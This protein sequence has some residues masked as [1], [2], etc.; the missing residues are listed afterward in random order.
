LHLPLEPGGRCAL[1]ESELEQWLAAVNRL[2]PRAPISR[3]E[4][5]LVQVGIQ[6][7]ARWDARSG[8]PAH[9]REAIWIDHAE[10]D[11]IAGLSTLVGV[12]Y[13]E[14][15]EEAREAVLR[16]AS[17]LGRGAP[18]AREPLLPGARGASAAQLAS[19]LRARSA[20]ALAPLQAEHLA[21]SYGCGAASLL[22]SAETPGL[23]EPLAPKSP[24]CGAE[25]T[26]A[27]RDEMA[28]SL[29]DAVLR[30]CELGARGDL[31]RATQ[32]RCADV[33]ARELGWSPEQRARELEALRSELARWTPQ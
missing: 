14:A 28:Q 11:G 17:V 13:T 26:R 22:E 6:P 2:L 27:F 10:R 24:V 1:G 5:A 9:A 20:G 19:E 33:A 15:P 21:A 8:L 3:S 23:L 18:P 31:D 16:I 29:A 30:R 32:E 4:V 25:I 12:K 7:V